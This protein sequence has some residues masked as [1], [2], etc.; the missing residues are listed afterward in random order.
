MK[1]PIQNDLFKSIKSSSK[2]FVEFYFIAP[3]AP[4]LR[5]IGFSLFRS[6]RYWADLHFA[7]PMLNT[8]MI[9][10][11]AAEAQISGQAGLSLGQSY[12]TSRR[13]LGGRNV[14]VLPNT[15]GSGFLVAYFYRHWGKMWCFAA[16]LKMI[17]KGHFSFHMVHESFHE[18]HVIMYVGGKEMEERCART[19][20]TGDGRVKKLFWV[21]GHGSAF[22]NLVS[23][24]DFG[25]QLSSSLTMLAGADGKC[26]PELSRS[27]WVE[28]GCLRTR[29]G[30]V[31]SLLGSVPPIVNSRCGVCVQF[32][33]GL[34][35]GK[36][37]PSGL[38]FTHTSYLF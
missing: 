12:K 13:G 36:G 8:Y 35:Q 2:W 9:W 20:C 19:A 23:S 5:F 24:T 34:C 7:L 6:W 38:I 10:A 3:R 17:L 31:W 37:F 30:M 21:S 22:P 1:T 26:S 32:Q 25:L 29:L 33:L 27:F 14:F 4:P 16:S 15:V 11:S 28:K 18:L